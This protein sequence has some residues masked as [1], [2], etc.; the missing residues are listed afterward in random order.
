VPPAVLAVRRNDD[1][2]VLLK[3]VKDIMPVPVIVSEAP[4]FPGVNTAVFKRISSVRPLLTAVKITAGGDAVVYGLVGKVT[5][6]AQVPRPLRSPA[7][8]EMALVAEKLIEVLVKLTKPPEI[9]MPPVI[10]VAAEATPL[11]NATDKARAASNL[12]G[13]IINSSHVLYNFVE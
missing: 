4:P 13:R 5:Q 3:P 8:C 7:V 1:N 12:M 2:G 10:S 6:A 9:D 11:L